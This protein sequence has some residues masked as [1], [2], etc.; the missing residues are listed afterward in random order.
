MGRG[1]NLL[2]YFTRHATVANLLLVVLI[3]L[4]LLSYPRMRAQFF[5]DVV[6]ESVSVSTSWQGAGAEDVDA[7]IVQ[8]MEPALL[9]VEGVESVSSRSFEGRAS[10]SIEFEPDWDVARAADDVQTAV[11]EISDLPE[12]ADTPQ[13]RRGA[14]RDSVT[15]VVISGPVGIEQLGR[16]ADEMIVRLFERGVT[17]TGIR[18]YVAPKTVVEVT[19]LSLIEHDVSMSDIASAIAG[20]VTADPAGDVASGAARV[21][22]GVAK[23]SAD[24]IEAI[25]IRANADGSKLRVGDVARVRVEGVDRDRSYFVGDDP[26]IALNVSR[27]ARGDAIQMQNIVEDVRAELLLTLPTGVEIDLVRTRSEL[28]TARLKMLMENGLQGLALVSLLLFLF[29]NART[30][31][32]VAAGIPVAMT[33]AIFLMYMSGLTINMVSLFAL[34]ITLGIVV[35]DAIVVGEHAD[36]RARRLGEGPVE[37]AENAAKRMFPPVFSATLTTIIAFFGLTSIGGRFGDLIAD[38]PF[39]VIVVLAASLIECFLILPH[40]M[41]HA[42]KHTAKEHWY[43]WPSRLVNKGFRWMRDYAFRPF[44]GFVVKA[45]YPVIALTLLILA[46]Q[47]SIF[48][49]GDLTFRFFNAPERSSVTGNFAMVSGATKDDT[50]EMMRL[51]QKAVEETAAEFEDEH[52]RNP[53]GSC[54]VSNWR[55]CWPGSGWGGNQG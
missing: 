35:D 37:A 44:M 32:W 33:T 25:V 11:D 41:A 18:G 47:A 34:I 39:T 1:L 22:T 54:T 40:H 51:V 53:G 7:A 20:E 52:G 30:A 12:D 46:S 27:S 23:R 3:A 13:V 14:W 38:I 4:G 2:S 26:A 28:I 17:R 36:F 50:L 19:S 21:R 24:Q 9:A 29:L 15:D 8:I 10:I 5:P 48:I 42:L 16:F 31:L 49:R 55:Q 6:I 43:D 45:R